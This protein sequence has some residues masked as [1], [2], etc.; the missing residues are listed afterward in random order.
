M[1]MDAIDKDIAKLVNFICLQV[2]LI[3]SLLPVRSF[4]KLQLFLQVKNLVVT[5]SSEGL[6]VIL[7][8]CDEFFFTLAAS[9]QFLDVLLQHGGFLSLLFAIVCCWE[10]RQKAVTRLRRTSM[11]RANLGVRGVQVSL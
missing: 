11:Q 3:S 8:I 2:D 7:E 4:F 10:V 1:S 9:D 6:V 5:A